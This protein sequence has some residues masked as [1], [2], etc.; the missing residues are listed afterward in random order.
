MSQRLR[1]ILLLAAVL[2]LVLV[3]ATIAAGQA[4]DV[5]AADGPA[6]EAPPEAA[7]EEEAPWTTRFLAPTVLAIGVIALVG[8]V[9]YYGVRVRGRYKVT[10]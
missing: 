2:A 4:T 7:E 10:S 6:V 5:F 1:L 3:P 9:L 8:S